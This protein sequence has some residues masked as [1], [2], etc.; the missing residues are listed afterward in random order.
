[1][2]PTDGESCWRLMFCGLQ[3]IFEWNIHVILQCVFFQ[4][5]PA[6]LPLED[7][8]ALFPGDHQRL[9]ASNYILNQS[10]PLRYKSAILQRALFGTT[11]V[12]RLLV[13][14]SLAKLG[15]WDRC[16]WSR[17]GRLVWYDTQTAG[18]IKNAV[19]QL[20]VKPIWKSPGIF[21]FTRA[22]IEKS[23]CINGGFECS[24]VGIRWKPLYKSR[25]FWG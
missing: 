19:R 20:K 21:F 14:G 15:P 17:V 13:L 10:I 11:R 7:L 12:S 25:L 23:I 24:P 6:P 16:W 4:A 2:T 5:S 18:G 9:T 8:L 22:H 3:N 1:M